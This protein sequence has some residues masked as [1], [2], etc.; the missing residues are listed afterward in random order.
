MCFLRLKT[1]VW[2]GVRAEIPNPAHARSSNALTSNITLSIQGVASSSHV[3]SIEK[4][5]SLLVSF[6]LIAQDVIF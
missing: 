5:I 3:Y 1:A 6:G 2:G 4:N